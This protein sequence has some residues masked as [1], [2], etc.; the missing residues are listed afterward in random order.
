MPARII[1]LVG[2]LLA[3]AGCAVPGSAAPQGF[4]EGS[5]LHTMSFGGLNRSY[6]LY[7]PAGWRRLHPS[8]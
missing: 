2:A 7:I 5:T 8:S 3:M 6:R 4:A 1:A